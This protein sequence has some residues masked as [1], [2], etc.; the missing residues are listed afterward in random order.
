MI[1]T[2]FPLILIFS[3]IFGVAT[4]IEVVEEG[5]DWMIWMSHFMAGFFLVFSFFKF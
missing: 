2:Y 3:Y 1:K 5:W 4:F